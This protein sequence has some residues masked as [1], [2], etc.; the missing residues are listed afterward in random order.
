M[1]IYDEKL[2]KEVWQVFSGAAQNNTPDATPDAK[3]D[4]TPDAKSPAPA[5][6]AP[7][8]SHSVPKASVAMPSLIKEIGQCS[9]T[10]KKKK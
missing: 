5:A 7:A 1:R 3:S 10:K 8:T 4:A 9:P 6:A 2:A